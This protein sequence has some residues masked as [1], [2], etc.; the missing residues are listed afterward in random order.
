MH[1]SQPELIWI[2]YEQIFYFIN[3]N[4]TDLM[5]VFPKCA[6][7][8]KGFVRAEVYLDVCAS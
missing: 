8:K 1:T 3:I 7:V 5:K 2:F 4:I 6:C